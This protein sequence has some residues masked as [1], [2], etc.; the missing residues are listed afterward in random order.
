MVSFDLDD[1]SGDTIHERQ[2]ISVEALERLIE[3]KPAT[4]PSGTLTYI[5]PHQ[6]LPEFGLLDDLEGRR[7]DV[8]GWA[9]LMLIRGEPA[10]VRWGH[11][12][13][14]LVYPEEEFEFRFVSTA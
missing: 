11:R 9:I 1:Y 7:I 8:P 5:P 4:N 12:T 2:P 10:R 14:V 3:G 6:I 13:D